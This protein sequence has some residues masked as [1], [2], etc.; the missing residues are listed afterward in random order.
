[1]KPNQPR[2]GPARTS[3]TVWLFGAAHHVGARLE[4]RTVGGSATAR[5]R[6]ELEN[7]RRKYRIIANAK[8]NCLRFNLP[9]KTHEGDKSDLGLRYRKVPSVLSP[10]GPFSYYYVFR[11]APRCTVRQAMPPLVWVCHYK[12][13]Q[14]YLDDFFFF[15]LLGEYYGTRTRTSSSEFRVKSYP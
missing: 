1:M 11:C 2:L 4:M 13:S 5:R 6:G 9:P 15:L 12:W 14:K 10:G 8:D 7:R 3:L